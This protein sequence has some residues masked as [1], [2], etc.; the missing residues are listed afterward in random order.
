MPSAP[1]SS[2]F[3]AY[4]ALVCTTALWGSNGV[5]SRALM[6][7]IP[8]LV[9][10]AARWAVVFVVLLPLV[11]PERRAIA[12][13]LRRDWKLLLALTLLG[14]APQ[15]ALVYSGLAASTAIH[16]G[17][18]NSTI[19]VFIILISWGWYARRPSRLEGVGLAISLI[20]VLLILVHGDLQSLLQLQFNQGDLLM[21][22]AVVIWAIYTLRLKHRPQSLSLFAFVFALSLIG[23]LLT[24]PFAALQWMRAGVHLGTREW[25]GLLYIGA[26]VTLVSSVLFGYGVDRVGAVRAGILIHLMP[27]FS[28]AF[29]ALFI[30]ERLFLYHAAGFVLVA[31]GAILGCL[32]PEPVLSSRASSKT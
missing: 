22:G 5:V 18:L 11:W 17:L 26:V 7:T 12:H 10:A 1:A 14:G 16:L 30:G 8:P 29:A 4:A 32:Q 23:E 20:G 24:L 21:L 28:S 15:T 13:S 6:D 19:P 31:G 2:R 27:V 9:M 3:L 25:L